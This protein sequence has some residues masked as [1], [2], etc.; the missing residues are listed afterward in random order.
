M[1]TVI[2]FLNVGH[3]DC[4][5][6]ESEGHFA[7]VDAAE[8]TDYPLDKPN[9]KLPGYEDVV[10]DY[11]LKNCANGDGKVILDFV[12][13]THSH[14]DHIGGF[15]TVINHPKVIVKKAYLKPY[16]EEN[17]V[18]YEVNRWDN[19]EVYTQMKEALEN[20]NVPIIEN[21][22]KECVL[23]GSF[24]IKFFNGKCR[25]LKKKIGENANSVVTLVEAFGKRALLAGDIN[26]KCGDEKA[27]SNE[28]GNVD[29]LKVGHHGYFFSTSFYWIKKLN[30]SIAIIPNTMARVYPDVKFKLKYVSKSKIYTTVESNG[31]K[32]VFSDKSIDIEK[33]IM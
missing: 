10:V 2:H 28:V 24:K 14:S 16:H 19:L 17:I 33:D 18:P 9:L 15:D 31:I 21:F 7:M 1:S 6:L 26:Y 8:D 32:A 25:F 22:D 11:L 12:L 23:L 13:G 27:I 5:I 29:L 3:S 20:K 4:I 30:P